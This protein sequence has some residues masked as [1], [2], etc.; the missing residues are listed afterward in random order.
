MDSELCYSGTA[1]IYHHSP[2][3]NEKVGEEPDFH[4]ALH[5]L[6]FAGADVGSVIP[7]A[8]C[9]YFA[10]A[11]TNGYQTDPSRCVTDLPLRGFSPHQVVQ[12]QTS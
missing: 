10:T 6:R 1:V 11:P 12:K 5:L 8:M 9:R 2:N 4:I 3:Q 7:Q